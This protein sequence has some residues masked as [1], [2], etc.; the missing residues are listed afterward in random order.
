MIRIGII[1][2]DSWHADDFS[3]IINKE[4][5][6]SGNSCYPEFVVTSILAEEEERAKRIAADNNIPHVVHDCWEMFPYVDAVMIVLRSGDAHLKPAAYFLERGIPV[7]VDKPIAIKI[8]DC[9][10]MIEIAKKN[11]TLLMGGSTCR[12]ME[13][14]Q[15]AKYFV[16]SESKIGQVITATMNYPANANSEYG[17][18]YFYGPHLCEMCMEIFGD[19]PRS[20]NA[21]EKA[22]SIY[23]IVDYGTFQVTLNFVEDT[24]DHMLMILGNKG[25][26]IRQLDSPKLPYYNGFERFAKQLLRKEA[27]TSFE[28]LLSSVKFV[29]AIVASYTRKLEISL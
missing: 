24:A 6:E 18:F 28:Q 12:Y 29:D 13:D 19:H 27:K 14:V 8:E 21:V 1:G 25:T 4:T 3:R 5:D 22:G 9:E 15:L 17:G 20:I 10:K 11:N 2:S 7:W 16:Q 26:L 23:A